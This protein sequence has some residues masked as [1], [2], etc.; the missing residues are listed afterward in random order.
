VKRLWCEF[1]WLGGAAV[2]PG[3]V[4]EVEAGKVGAVRLGVPEPPPDAV[5]LSGYTLP[6]LANAHSHAFQ[7]LFRGKTEEGQGNFWSW[8][9]QMYAAAER[10]DPDSYLELARATFG[11]M[12][13]AG[14]TTVGEFHYVH[15]GQGGSPYADPNAMGAAL[16]AAA[17]QAGI[18]IT[19]IDACYLS[20]GFG[21]ELDPVQRRFSDGSAVAWIE[22]VE[23]LEA[24]PQARVGGAVHSVRAVDPDAAALI[25]QWAAAGERPLHAH[26]SE[27]P[28]ENDECRAAF[29]CSPTELL[30]EA[31]ALSERFTAVHATHLSATDL[32]LLGRAGACCCFC[33]TTERDLADGIGPA[34]LLR[35][36]GANLAV[37]SDSQAVIDIFEE[38]RAIELDE[39]LATQERGCHDPATLLGAATK[40]GHAAVG[41]PDC[42]A[43]EP[44]MFADLVNLDA[45]GAAL[46]GI[47]ADSALG[48]IVFAAGAGDVTNV[49]VGGEFVVRHGDHVRIDVPAELRTAIAQLGGRS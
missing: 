4:V 13:L 39:R 40:Q 30:A 42:G 33:P 34:L 29:H 26:V 1:A 8:R 32:E 27:Q 2:T 35:E 23:A 44:G 22:R 17:E 24:G 12:A 11:E 43:I 37:G 46:A 48:S 49:L 16:V 47:E 7:R 38:C 21:A 19:L 5:A 14:I 31:G 36:A 18:R 41:W 28:R 9:E 25:A 15:H 45:S 6:G 10:L 20:G 3:V